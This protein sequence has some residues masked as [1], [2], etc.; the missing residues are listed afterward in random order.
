[1]SAAALLLMTCPG[2][3]GDVGSSVCSVGAGGVVLGAVTHHPGTA[4]LR[5]T[6]GTWA[7]HLLPWNCCRAYVD[8]GVH[9]LGNGVRRA[10][11]TPRRRRPI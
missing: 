4:C 1:M 2:A 7:P 6:H 10:G 9:L 3:A 8:A 5:V 11:C